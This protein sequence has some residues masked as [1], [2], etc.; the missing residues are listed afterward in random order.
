MTW[1]QIYNAEI[2]KKG[3]LLPFILN[4]ERRSSGALI[5]RI[6][7][8][9]PPGSRILEIG[10]GTGAIGA[11][12]CKYGFNV[13][14]IDIDSE[15]VTIAKKSFNLFGKSEKVLLLDARNVVDKFGYDSFD[16]VITHGMLEHYEDKDI[17]KHLENQLKI[18][19]LAIC[20]VPMRTMSDF[21]KSRGLGDE[22][23]LSTSYWKRM[24]RKNF[25]LKDTY[26]FGFKETNNTYLSEKILKI[27]FIAKIVAPLCAFNEFWI[28][29]R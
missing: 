14:G 29:P 18:S 9:L 6:I 26:G 20:V 15:M 5:R 8:K 27:D 12:L 22:R 2:S 21:Y 24:I 25:Q 7:E 10:T 3:G 4:K 11:L 17:I 28:T 19:P 13:T 1:S 16:C 23:Y